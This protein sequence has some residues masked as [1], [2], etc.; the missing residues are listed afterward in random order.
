MVTDMT[1]EDY[2]QLAKAPGIKVSVNRGMAPFTIQLNCRSGPTAD[3]N[4]RKALAYAIDYNAFLQIENGRARLLQSPFPDGIL[5]HLALTDMPRQ[6][7]DKAR[8]YLA[9][10]KSPKG[11]LTLE[12]AYVSGLEV[13]RQI[14]LAALEALQKLDITVSLSAMPWPTL[15]A[16]GTKPETAPSMMAVYVTPV[17]TDPDVIAS[18]YAAAAGGS[19]WGMHHLDDPQLDD[20]I[21]NAR[22]ETDR[23]KRLTQYAAIQRRILADQPA[24]FGMV[25]DRQWAMHDYV[26]GFQFC[27]VRLTGEADFYPM[28]IAAG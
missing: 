15:V 9:K 25:E 20:M 8:A 7:L 11:G 5:G 16:R 4:F 3:V 12:Y 28:S 2:D 18:Q 22:I 10:T 13:E 26:E 27:P 14:G 1:P 17:S 23:D 6:D 24:I 19:F 21:G